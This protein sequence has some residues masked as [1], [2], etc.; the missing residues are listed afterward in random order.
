MY[1]TEYKLSSAKHFDNFKTI[2]KNAL[3]LASSAC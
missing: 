1:N 3:A 2:W